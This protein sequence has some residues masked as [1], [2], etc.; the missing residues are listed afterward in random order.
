MKPPYMPNKV[1]PVV[2]QLQL[3]EAAEIE[4]HVPPG[5]SFKR[6]VQ[7]DGVIKLMRSRHPQYFRRDR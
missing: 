1:L 2:L 4:P 5:M 6:T 7:L 3:V